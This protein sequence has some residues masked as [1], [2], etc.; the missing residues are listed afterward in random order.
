MAEPERLPV[1]EVSVCDGGCAEVLVVDDAET[2]AQAVR[3]LALIVQAVRW[4][5]ALGTLTLAEAA[6]NRVVATERVW[7]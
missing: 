1:Y 3:R 5:G 6:T 2:R 4:R 7:P